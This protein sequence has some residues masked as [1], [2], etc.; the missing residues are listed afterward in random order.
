LASYILQQAAFLGFEIVFL[1]EGVAGIRP[2][3]PGFH[4]GFYYGLIA[5][6]L[7]GEAIDFGLRNLSTQQP[8]CLMSDENVVRWKRIRS[9]G[10]SRYVLLHIILWVLCAQVMPLDDWIVE[11]APFFTDFRSFAMMCFVFA[12]FGLL[13]GDDRWKRNERNYEDSV[14]LQA[15]VMKPP[16]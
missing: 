16:A 9:K 2:F 12:L 15:D 6:W 10:K 11:S 3:S 7:L 13:I 4:F 1:A 8:N 14:R 5:I